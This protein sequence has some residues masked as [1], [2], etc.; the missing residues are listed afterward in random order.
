MHSV[1]EIATRPVYVRFSWQLDANAWRCNDKLVHSSNAPLVE[2]PV[3]SITLPGTDVFLTCETQVCDSPDASQS[4]LGA[5]MSLTHWLHPDASHG[6]DGD[7]NTNHRRRATHRCVESDWQQLL[8]PTDY[9]SDPKRPRPLLVIQMFANPSSRLFLGVTCV[10]LAAAVTQPCVLHESAVPVVCR[11][12][13]S[14]TMHVSFVSE[15]MQAGRSASAD[16]DLLLQQVE[17][18][19]LRATKSCPASPQ[20]LGAAAARES[21]AA[22]EGLESARPARRR[23]TVAHLRQLGKKLLH[24]TGPTV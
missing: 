6:S 17:N 11:G 8:L 23:S 19:K 1:P 22:K 16:A 2:L 4:A 9:I 14:G 10:D 5:S 13:L 20:C 3:M 18:Q 15:G 12:K 24:V 7:S 21:T